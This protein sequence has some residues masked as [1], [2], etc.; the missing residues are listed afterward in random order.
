MRQIM[1]ITSK[2][3]SSLS[4]ARNDAVFGCL[5]AATPVVFSA[6]LIATSSVLAAAS[7]G[8]A[9]ISVILGERL[10]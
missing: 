6:M 7:I 4:I 9:Y 5:L 2:V 1:N 3:S 10:D 8:L